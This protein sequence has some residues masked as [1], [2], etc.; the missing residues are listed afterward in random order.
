MTDIMAAMG[1]VQLERYPELLARRK[2]IIARYDRRL[3]EVDGFESFQH[4]SDNM[5]S[6]GHLYLVNLTG[7]SVAFRN[8]VIELMDERGIATNVHY[9][10]L[11]MMTAYQ[12][13]G[14]DIADYP[15]AYRPL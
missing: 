2:Q 13:M 12:A 3:R 15:N 10:P 4:F 8:R 5:T 11:P 14:F 7:K 6:S 9:K 1:L